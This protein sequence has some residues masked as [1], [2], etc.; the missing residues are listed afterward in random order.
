MLHAVLDEEFK[1][2]VYLYTLFTTCLIALIWF[3][4]YRCRQNDKSILTFHIFSWQDKPLRWLEKYQ[5]GTNIINLRMNLDD[6]SCFLLL[7]LPFLSSIGRKVAVFLAARLCAEDSYSWTRYAALPSVCSKLCY[8]LK[9]QH[10]W[11]WSYT[12][13]RKLSDWP[14]QSV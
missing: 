2:L 9:G 5:C 8:T 14:Q 6:N 11:I 10:F 12:C 4:A 13:C 3:R 1:L 7:F